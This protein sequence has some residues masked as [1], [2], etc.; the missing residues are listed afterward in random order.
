MKR[1]IGTATL[2]L[3]AGIAQPYADERRGDFDNALW[4]SSKCHAYELNQKRAMEIAVSVGLPGT[5]SSITVTENQG[6]SSMIS[7]VVP[8]AG[9]PESQVSERDC[10][11]AYYWFGPQGTKIKGLLRLRTE[12]PG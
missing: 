5:P 11:A 3:L 10:R 2:A 7:N 9:N 6:T 8:F 4:Y 1:R 12:Q